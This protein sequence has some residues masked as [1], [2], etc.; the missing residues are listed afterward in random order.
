MRSYK[1]LCTFATSFPPL[2]TPTFYV[3]RTP[4]DWQRNR[5]P[6]GLS[7]HLSVHLQPAPELIPAACPEIHLKMVL[8]C[9][10]LESLHGTF[11]YCV[12]C[13]QITL[14][15]LRFLRILTN[16]TS[17]VLL[18]LYTEASHDTMNTDNSFGIQHLYFTSPPFPM[19][20]IFVSFSGLWHHYRWCKFLL[21]SSS[22]VTARTKY[23]YSV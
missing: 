11:I 3:P 10:H 8:H 16:P 6:F 19:C 21:P 17:N 2:P 22:T 5:E 18:A 12:L 1:I 9:T 23:S 7:L 15:T 4:T 20:K 14:N 13:C